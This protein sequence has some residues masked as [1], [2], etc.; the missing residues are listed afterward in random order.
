MARTQHKL[1]PV[2]RLRESERDDLRLRLADAHRAADVLDQERLRI[3][4]ELAELQQQRQAAAG[5]RALDPNRVMEAQRY[6]MILQSQKSALAEK[7]QLVEQ[8]IA[9]RQAAVTQADQRVK[10]IEKLE[11]R[12]AD[13]HRREL[14]RAE[15]L[16]MDEAAQAGAAR[17][18]IREAAQ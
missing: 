13:A 8:E 15:A 12:R 1:E 6:A 10:V 3:E 14:E 18:A 11:E 4:T 2:R 7:Q 5:A 9:R 17:R 16:Q